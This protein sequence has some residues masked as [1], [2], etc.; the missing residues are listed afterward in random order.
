MSP[1][2][3]R[4]EGLSRDYRA[5]VSG[6]AEARGHLE[7]LLLM[8][9]A[10]EAAHSSPD[11]A[12]YLDA[13]VERIMAAVGVRHCSLMLCDDTG[14]LRIAAARGLPS[15]VI[16][17]TRLAPGEG[18]A[19]HVLAT[20][21][22]LL[23][24][25][26]DADER[27]G[28]R[29]DFDHYL[30][31]SLLSVPLVCRGQVRGVLNVTNK[32]DDA[33]FGSIDLHLLNGVAHQ[34]MLALENFRLVAEL[35]QS[36]T[37]LERSNVRLQQLLRGRSRLV[38]NLSHEL[39]TPLTSV[40]GYVDLAL[41]HFDQL[42]AE[43]LRAYLQRV[44]GEGL[45]M[46]QLINDMLTL[47]S[48][49]SGFGRWEEQLVDVAG[50]LAGELRRRRDDIERMRLRLEYHRPAELPEVPAD[51]DRLRYLL[52]A[53]VDNAI[54]FNCP[55]GLLEVRLRPLEGGL[56]LH[57]FNQGTRVPPEAADVIFEQYTQLGDITSG[58]PP[59]VGIGLAIC[60][61]IVDRLGGS[62]QLVPRGDDGTGVVV[63]F[64]RQERLNDEK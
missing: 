39:K 3:P 7:D 8:R 15:E 59:G 4:D 27:F 2:D 25:D 28:S 24:P 30:S 20:G 29:N 1:T 47:F 44:H 43:E 50:M 31:R 62:I 51:P 16:A 5:L 23:I 35:Q 45:Q 41:N 49:E 64:P 17:E 11:L 26:L 42:D 52:A 13:L 60:R 10:A 12:S 21:E 33:P 19:G 38:C 36:R 56:E 58:K 9:H 48:L 34:A 61:A 22:P 32:Q 18:I 57:V 46:K 55:G 6:E 53:L 37:E 14:W 40:L 54:K 63:R